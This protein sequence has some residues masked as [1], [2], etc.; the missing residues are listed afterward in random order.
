[1]PEI[2]WFSTV[3]SM[4]LADCSGH[5]QAG[6]RGTHSLV[7]VCCRG[8]AVPHGC[9]ELSH[10]VIQS[11][12]HSIGARIKGVCHLEPKRSPAVHSAPLALTFELRGR[13][14]G[15]ERLPS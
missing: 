15:T 10:S 11:E 9:H 8:K 5:L 1:M 4:P 3:S 2:S 14:R 13:G 6:K 12:D 7:S